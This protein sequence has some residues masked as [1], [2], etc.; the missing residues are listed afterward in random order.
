M[1]ALVFGNDSS[2]DVNEPDFL[3]LYLAQAVVDVEFEPQGSGIRGESV[4]FTS[5]FIQTV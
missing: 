3:G 4:C 1:A 2:W 5:D